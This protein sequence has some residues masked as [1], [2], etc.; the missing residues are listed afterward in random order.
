MCGSGLEFEIND[1]D[2]EDDTEEYKGTEVEIK[3]KEGDKA[4][5]KKLLDPR[6]PSEQEVE[7]HDM[8]YTMCLIGTGVQCAFEVKAKT[9]TIGSRWR[10]NEGLQSTHL[11][12]ASLGASSV[13][14]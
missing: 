11:T 8:N 12:T 5:I 1:V 6:K 10:K 2:D 4:I 3:G 7:N 14:S 13:I 9:W